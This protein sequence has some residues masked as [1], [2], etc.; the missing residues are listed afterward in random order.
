[1]LFSDTVKLTLHATYS[2][3]ITEGTVTPSQASVTPSQTT[4]AQLTISSD[5]VSI[6]HISILVDVTEK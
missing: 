3:S 5:T 2:D 4:M 6:V 1:M